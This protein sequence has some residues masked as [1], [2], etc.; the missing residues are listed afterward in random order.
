MKEI[1][2][3]N[4]DNHMD[5]TGKHEDLTGRYFGRLQAIRQ[6]RKKGKGWLWLCLCECLNTCEC[7]VRQLK[8]G[9]HNHCGCL[10]T[11]K[12]PEVNYNCNIPESKPVWMTDRQLELLMLIVPGPLGFGMSVTTAAK[13]IGI[14]KRAGFLRL[15][16][17]KMRFPSAWKKIIRMMTVMS[18]QRKALQNESPDGFSNLFSFDSFVAKHGQNCAETS[19]KKCF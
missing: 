15:Q 1:E 19:I 17:F 6:T 10:D 16:K 7:S 3:F 14:S 2:S 8:R 5:T 18:R 4:R 13:K 12:T 9:A 11:H